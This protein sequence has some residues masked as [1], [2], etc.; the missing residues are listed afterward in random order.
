LKD[1]QAVLLKEMTLPPDFE[2]RMQHRLRDEWPAFQSSLQQSSPTSIR[3][4]PSKKSIAPEKK[5]P[6]TETGYYLE[7]RPRFTLDPL[8]HAGV[9]YV[10]EA[11]SMLVEQ[12]VRQSM[13]VTQPILALDL[14]AAPGGKSTHLLSLLSP[15]SFLVSNEVIRARASVLSENIQKWG[16]ENVLVTSND[17]IDF[18]LLPGF[19]DL[20][21]VDAP[22]SGE[23][24]FRKD[25]AAMKEW[26]V[27]NVQLCAQRQQRIV[28]DVWPSLKEEGILLYSTCTYS[29][30]ENE[31]NLQW[32]AN[33]KQV[34]FVSLKLEA[35]WGVEEVKNGNVLGYR[36]Y[37]HRVN[38]EGFF[39][40]IVRKKS[41]EPAKSFRLKN[42]VTL[43]SKK[44]NEALHDWMMPHN[45]TF[46]QLDEY[47]LSV[48]TPFLSALNTLF[49]LLKPVIRGTAVAT[50]KHDK[51]IPEHALALSVHVNTDRF[52]KLY[53][54]YEEA[55]AYL[56]KDVLTIGEGEKGFALVMYEGVPL[57]WVN[58]LGN[59]LNNLYP[60]GWRIMMRS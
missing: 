52:K 39:L 16:Y 25:Q 29:E 46:V 2:M 42:N 8:F 10:Q 54:T 7:E 9:Y 21:V 5:I 22:C 35:S 1:L 37:P 3:L 44:A 40:A 19:F 48:S 47:I 14:C 23:G 34:E 36:C 31:Q 17:P 28:A 12:G 45:H 53:L 11:S 30:E 20:I 60:A 50:Q 4:N 51:F 49:H 43:I 32:L 38:G 6:W 13:E 33:D 24:L 59:R 57:G 26:S 55:L 18:Q 15:D 56:R 58:L 27:G 41:H